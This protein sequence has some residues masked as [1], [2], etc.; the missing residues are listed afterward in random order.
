MLSSRGSSYPGVKS[1]SLVSCTG[2]WDLYYYYPPANAGDAGGSFHF[3]VGKMPW[4]RKWQITPVFLPGKFHGQR[5]L[6]GCSPWGCQESD[7]TEQLSVHTCTHTNTH[8]DFYH[9]KFFVLT[10]SCSKSMS[11]LLHK[12]NHPCQT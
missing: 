7:M 3:W 10:P 4:S 2:R 9:I 11:T 6:V 8:T 12:A 1:T 5:S